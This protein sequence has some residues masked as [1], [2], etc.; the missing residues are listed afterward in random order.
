MLS[1]RDNSQN[2]TTLVVGVCQYADEY[3]KPRPRRLVEKYP[4][5]KPRPFDPKLDGYWINMMTETQN[6][7]NKPF[8]GE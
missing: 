5:E 6:A 1:I 3:K 8:L 4:K 7:I 2:P